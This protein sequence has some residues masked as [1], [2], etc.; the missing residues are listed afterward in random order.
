MG[1]FCAAGAKDRQGYYNARM[2]EW[3]QILLL[4]FANF[5]VAMF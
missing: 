5:V 4:N 2:R 1:P 3:L